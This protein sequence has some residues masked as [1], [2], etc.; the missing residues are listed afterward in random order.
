M[1]D[2]CINRIGN[3]GFDKIIKSKNY[4]SILDIKIDMNKITE[5][6]AKQLTYTC[7]ID[8]LTSLMIRGN[9][10]GAKGCLYL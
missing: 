1:L 6:G 4:P 10:F 7:N 9:T 8:S 3:E 5:D 2:L